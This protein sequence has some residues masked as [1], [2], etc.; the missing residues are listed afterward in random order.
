MA[1]I[2]PELKIDEIE[3]WFKIGLESTKKKIKPL[4][5]SYLGGHIFNPETGGVYEFD[6]QRDLDSKL[7][8]YKRSN[9]V[10]N[11]QQYVEEF[12]Q[13]EQEELFSKTYGADGRN[14]P[15]SLANELE[16]L[17]L[18]STACSGLPS[19]HIP[20]GAT[21]VYNNYSFQQKYVELPVLSSKEEIVATIESNQVTIVQG[22]TG[23]GKTTQ[24]PQFILDH[25]AT[26]SKY[27]NI[28]VTQPRKI[29]AIS[30]AQRVS[31]ERGCSVGSL[32]G[33]QIGLERKVSADTRILYCTTGILKEKLILKKN[34]HEFTHVILDEVHERDIETDFVLLIIKKLLRT[35]SGHV[36]VILMSA[37]FDTQI[38]ANYFAI[39]LRNKLEPAPIVTIGAGHHRVSEFFAD[40]LSARLGEFPPVDESKP[41][42]HPALYDIVI[43]LVKEFDLL[44][45]KEQGIDQRTGFAPVRGTVL[46]FLPGY[47]EIT[48]IL[49]KIRQLEDTHFI[50]PIPLHSSITLDEQSKAFIKPAKGYRKVIIST[51]IAESSITVPD[52]KYVIDFCLTKNL[53]CDP[54][55]N[56]TQLQLEWASKANAKQRKGRAGRVSN[57]RVY[58]LVPRWFFERVLPDFGTPEMQRAPLENLILKTKIFNMGEPKAILALAL[59]PPNLDDIERTI[60]SLKEVGALSSTTG[61]SSNPHD[62]DLTF[63]G[64]VLADLPV[65]IRIGKLFILGHVFGVLEECLI[66]G[67]ALSLKSIFATPMQARLEAYKTKLSWSDNS[68]SDC[69]AILNAYKVWENRVK[70]KE[71]SRAGA[72]EKQWG[73]KNFIQIRAIKEV[74]KLIEEL[75][76]RLLKFNISSPQVR[77]SFKGNHTSAVERIILKLVLCGAFYPNYAVKEETD[78]HEAVKTLSNNDPLK[79][80]MVKGLPINQGI[81]YQTEIRE[82]F[83]SCWKDP[84]PLISFEQTRAYIEFPWKQGTMSEGRVHPGVYIAIKIRQLGVKMGLSMYDKEETQKR[85]KNVQEATAS[86]RSTSDLRTN[87]MKADNIVGEKQS[88]YTVTIDPNISTLLLSVTEVMECGHFW[89]Q[90]DDVNTQK[91]LTEVQLAL[92]SPKTILKPFEHSLQQGML[93]A[94][95]YADGTVQYYRARIEEFT[96]QK[97]TV[98]GGTY[99]SVL[100]AVV[101][102]V[103]YGNTEVIDVSQL[104]QLPPNCLT[105]PFLAVEFYLKGIRPSSVRCTDGVWSKQANEL[106]KTW[107]LNKTLYAQVYSIVN[108]TVRVS[109]VTRYPNGQEICVN[110]ELIQQ[111]FAVQAEETFLSQ[112]NHEWR[113]SLKTGESSQV[114]PD[115]WLQVSVPDNTRPSDV[116]SRGK[117]IFLVG[118]YNPLEMTFSCLTSG[119]R[120][121]SVKIDPESVNSVAIDD[122]PQNK[123]SR[124]MV[125]SFIGLNQS[126]NSMV[127]RN[128]TILPQIPGLPALVTLVFAPF[129]EYRTDPKCERYIGAL[130]GL[131]YDED[132]LPILPDHDIALTFETNFGTDDIVMINQVRMAINVALGTED[133]VVCWGQDILTRIQET[134]RD[135]LLT[136]LKKKREPVTPQNFLRPYDWNLV[137]PNLVLVF[138]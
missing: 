132:N 103:D 56:Y 112:Q 94:A 22:P 49:D 69:I 30:I 33:Y 31:D 137:D 70:M 122:D 124:L 131:G 117:K 9:Y 53:C 14:V 40:D 123:Y 81:L 90:C 106:F 74:Q 55:T 11:R 3:D 43:G 10:S 7:P 73:A 84:P 52:I 98:A 41:E 109:L 63:I 114:Q 111:E 66:I 59:S 116:R 93:V 83:K 44:E 27:C 64:K 16:A 15:D 80:V 136:L 34:M 26:E 101:F 13:K 35:N 92:N 135:K 24:V 19:D 85:L 108:N 82:I 126:G 127:A 2:T 88:S 76:S 130:C 37:T 125:S 121:L 51:N 72:T 107:T 95:P 67:A 39:P 104:K 89:A 36:K 128:T 5:A 6:K 29:A 119:G 25:Y 134:A 46:M 21:D 45:E 61:I 54:D 86:Q 79:T 100:S 118:P 50:L 87:R 129:V 20:E 1:F 42:I 77:P 78:E 60:L 75:E 17:E 4:A 91:Y 68:L 48:K 28:V 96:T 8:K 32:C 102:Y 65:D 23:S 47:Y 12:V 71:F 120:Q 133:A 18:D 110:D 105:Q 38:F 113:E 57:G 99:R 97:V 58:Y 115:S 138:M 62:G